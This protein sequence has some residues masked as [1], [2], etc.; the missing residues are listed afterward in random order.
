M[1]S[2]D[3]LGNKIYNHPNCF[4]SIYVDL[5]N[6]R[7]VRTLETLAKWARCS[8][9]TRAELQ[10]TRTKAVSIREKHERNLL[11][12]ST[13]LYVICTKTTSIRNRC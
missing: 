9:F 5:T 2:K 1:D 13:D 6:S 4:P 11:S 3:T 12:G 7:G 10:T 8:M